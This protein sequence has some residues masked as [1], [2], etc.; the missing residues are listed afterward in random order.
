MTATPG[1]SLASRIAAT[2]GKHTWWLAGNLGVPGMQDFTTYKCNCGWSGD[3]PHEHQAAAVLAL[4]QPEESMIPEW[5]VDAPCTCTGPDAP[6]HALQFCGY[7]GH[8]EFPTKA[9]FVSEWVSA[10]VGGS[11]T[12]TSVLGASGTAESTDLTEENN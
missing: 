10:S 5:V 9:R 6:N 4:F 2:L 8:F 3:E 12:T 7:A 1:P 11:D